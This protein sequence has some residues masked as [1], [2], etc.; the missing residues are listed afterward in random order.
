M[1]TQQHALKIV[2]DAEAKGVT[3]AFEE[4]IKGA[5]RLE[6]A[7]NNLAK[8]SNK[9]GDKLL[10]GIGASFDRMGDLAGRAGNDIARDFTKALDKIPDKVNQIEDAFLGMGKTVATGMA[11]AA[12]AGVAA[13]GTI[14]TA[15]FK[16]SGDTRSAAND[17]AASL[18]VIPEE[19]EKYAKVARDVWANNFGES[20]RSVG[21]DVATVAKT[22]ELAA[23]EFIEQRLVFLIAKV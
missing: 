8:V 12:A 15:A 6:D 22:L 20:I 7:L 11:A 13:I 3:K 21:G 2:I 5:D 18:G 4:G 19:A 14:A 23:D 16:A 1:A 9:A 10:D 17:I